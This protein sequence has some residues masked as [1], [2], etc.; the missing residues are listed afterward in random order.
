[1]KF[2]KTQGSDLTHYL[3]EEP[4]EKYHLRLSPLY[5]SLFVKFVVSKQQI[6]MDLICICSENNTRKC[7]KNQTL[8]QDVRISEKTCQI[9]QVPMFKSYC[10]IYYVI[11]GPPEKKYEDTESTPCF[12]RIFHF[13]VIY[14][15]QQFSQIFLSLRLYPPPLMSRDFP[16]SLHLIELPHS[17]TAV[18]QDKIPSIWFSLRNLEDLGLVLISM[19][20]NCHCIFLFL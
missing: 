16:A 17:E 3:S 11:S 14:L 19:Y 13:W 10:Y 7:N 20:R 2:K 5:Y 18:I 4:K 8:S 1:M 15:T 6:K 9:T 12:D